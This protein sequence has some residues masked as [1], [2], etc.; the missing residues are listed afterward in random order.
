MRYHDVRT[1]GFEMTPSEKRELYENRYNS[2]AAIR[3]GFP[4]NGYD[5]FIL[6]N[7]ELV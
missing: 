2:E 7:G 3:L 1:A 5:A 4:I 6:L